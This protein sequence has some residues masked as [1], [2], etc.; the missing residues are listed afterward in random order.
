M[1]IP[2]GLA[3]QRDVITPEKEAEII[4]WL[5]SHEWSNELSRRTQHF[6][7]QYNYKGR[8]LTPGTPLDGPILEIAQLLEKA[9]LMIPRSMYR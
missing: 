9:G 6:G 5:D 3:L 4:T 8:N 7:Y 2:L 1:D